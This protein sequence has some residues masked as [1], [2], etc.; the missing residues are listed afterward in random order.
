MI[1]TIELTKSFPCTD[2]DLIAKIPDHEFNQ[3]GIN[4]VRIFNQSTKY[5]KLY[6]DIKLLPNVH[7]KRGLNEFRLIRNNH[8]CQ[9][10]M[11]INVSHLI[12][13]SEP[14]RAIRITSNDFDN[15]YLK[16]IDLITSMCTDL[17][18]LCNVDLQRGNAFS[19]NRI[20]YA[21]D[22]KTEYASEYIRLLKKG[23]QPPKLL[24]S[25]YSTNL[26]YTNKSSRTKLLRTINCY[27]KSRAAQAKGNQAEKN[28]LRFE[29]QL[30]KTQIE[31][32]LENNNKNH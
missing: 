25:G 13:Y 29:V 27:D 9:V 16:T 28:L 17:A 6:Y 23:Y 24:D 8:F 22:I 32:Y 3:S 31:T 18:I 4:V 21:I 15:I 1:H 10:Y 20:D 7:I 30:G 2:F 26:Y 5:L 19:I 14:R 12:G 11:T